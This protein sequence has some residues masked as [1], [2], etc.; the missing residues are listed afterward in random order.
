MGH[1]KADPFHPIFFFLSSGQRTDVASFLLAKCFD[2]AQSSDSVCLRSIYAF[3][4]LGCYSSIVIRRRY[5]RCL[6]SINGENRVAD[7]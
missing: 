1:I 6:N 7:D 2:C 4:F 3:F 5:D